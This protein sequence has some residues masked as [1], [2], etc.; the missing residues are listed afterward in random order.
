MSTNDLWFNIIS[1]ILSGLQS[2]TNWRS[3]ESLGWREGCLFV[4]FLFPDPN[5]SHGYS[6]QV[7]PV[8]GSNQNP[9]FCPQWH[10]GFMSKCP[11]M[12]L[13]KCPQKAL[14]ECFNLRNQ[15]T[16]ELSRIR[17][18]KEVLPSSPCLD[19][20]L[21]HQLV[22]LP[23]SSFQTSVTLFSKS[24]VWSCN[25]GKKIYIY[26][27]VSIIYRIKTNLLKLPF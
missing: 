10:F 18:R 13:S 9:Y 2:F 14:R 1:Q 22:T 7:H 16:E 15:T 25:S 23:P 27:I 19:Q 12:P 6:A 20:D 5:E 11:G 8:W 17:A 21:S 3:H 26:A 4:E 24:Q